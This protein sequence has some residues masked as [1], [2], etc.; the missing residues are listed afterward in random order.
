MKETFKIL[1]LVW[2]IPI[3]AL[4]NN[5]FLPDRVIENV[6]DG[7]IVTY[8]F[9]DPII[10]P[11]HLV[12]GSFFWKYMGFGIND[13]SG[14][15]A[16]P[17]R[18]DMFYIP[19]GYKAQVK[20]LNAIYRD[21]TF[22]LSPAIPNPP[23]DG[24]AIAIDSIIPYAGNFP[25]SVLKYGP[26]S[27]YRDVGL[28][29]V[30]TIP[31]KYNYSQHKVRAYTEIK[32]KVTFVPDNVE[33]C[34]KG[35]S[36]F[37]K[38]DLIST[39]LSNVTLNYAA[40]SSPS[41]LV[42]DSIW[43]CV[44]NLSNYLIIS[45]SEYWNAIQE[46]AKW[47]R[48]KGNNVYTLTL[49]KGEWTT[50]HVMEFIDEFLDVMDLHYV[51]I[52]GGNDDVPGNAFT[53]NYWSN[54]VLVTAHAVSDFEY[55]QPTAGVPKFFRGRIPADSTQQV[56]RVLDKIIQ[57]EKNP[58]INDDFYHTGLNCAEFQDTDSAHI[59][60]YE[61]R[62]F[63]LTSENIREHLLMLGYQVR[64]QYVRTS[65]INT[66]YWS[67]EYGNGLLLPN[68][69]QPSNF[70]WNGNYY[71]IAYYINNGVFYALHR[72]H[73]ESDGW[74]HPSF[75]TSDVNQ[76]QNG[77]R[78]PVVFS[79]NC[80][81]GK[82]NT[83]IDCFAEAF[84]KKTN[85]GCSGIF[86]ATETSFSGYNDAMALGMFDAIWPN[87]QPTYYFTSYYPVSH[88]PIYELGPI[89]D[90]GL[91]RM[92]E[93]Y[94]WNNDYWSTI[95]QKIFHCFGDPSM[96]IYTDTPKKFAEPSIFSR[97]DS[98]FVF[99]EDGDCTI[100]FYDKVTEDVKSYKGNYAGYAN[101]SD[102]L[103]ICLDRH[104]YVPYIWDYT[105][106]IYIQNEDIQNETRVYKGNN[107]YVGKNVTP[108]KPIGN[109]NIQ[110]AHITIQG[111]RLEL[112]PNTRIDKNFKFTNR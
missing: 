30:T 80:K 93:T 33:S 102:S 31:I 91:Q 78:L 88:S 105:K 36:P 10:Q 109:V 25:N 79:L 46:F 63:V 96:Q 53:Y 70:S 14:E 43:H 84:L 21:T 2:L 57:Y 77:N 110:N 47:K 34:S 66:L 64:R 73:G 1:L 103:I 76:L 15:P 42:G 95:T 28:L 29:R 94:G 85:G 107:I 99:I 38:S 48:L 58:V 92:R 52:V 20:M 12:P 41:R 83:N 49:P 112:R 50:E 67:S 24:S 11:N 74:Y 45:I 7:V 4:S 56:V 87:L 35:N 104:N 23:D 100:T 9:K 37:S 18:T 60:G 69:L 61:D 27:V 55:G 111:K 106:D 71:R 16:V 6:A 68:E 5:D 86:A 72:D 26:S 22:V 40:H 54:N 19:A 65:N 32:Y 8:N 17:F 39:F 3:V 13:T 90:H 98:I 59:D 108:S 44:P 82:Y 81:T 97:G 75:K 101:P 62:C 51:L 89:L